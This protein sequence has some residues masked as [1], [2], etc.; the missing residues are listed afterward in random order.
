MLMPDG[1]LKHRPQGNTAW[2]PDHA[3]D[4]MDNL[5]DGRLRVGLGLGSAGACAACAGGDAV[6]DG[7]HFGADEDIVDEQPQH[8][9]RS[10]R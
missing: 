3:P 8:R 6:P 2:R 9:W 4:A 10:G 7:D 5:A 1:T